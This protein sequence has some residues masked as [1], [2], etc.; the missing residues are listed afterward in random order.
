[1]SEDDY[2]GFVAQWDQMAARMA[3]SIRA[4]DRFVRRWSR[5]ETGWVAAAYL[6]GV[7]YGYLIEGW[8]GAC[9]GSVASA[10]PITAFY[11]VRAAR[12]RA[13]RKREDV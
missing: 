6:I 4:G 3:E 9:I 5:I 12:W 8:T 13:A 2:A 11:Q 10:A 7:G 1:M